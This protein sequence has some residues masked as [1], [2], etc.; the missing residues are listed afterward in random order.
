VQDLTSL[1]DQFPMACPVPT[2]ICSFPATPC[3]TGLLLNIDNDDGS[4]LLPSVL[5]DVAVS[6]MGKEG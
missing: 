2:Y 5:G 3:K 1:T 4:S 6:S